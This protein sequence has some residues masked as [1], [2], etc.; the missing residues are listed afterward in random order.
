MRWIK[1]SA[2]LLI[3]SATT[4]VNAGLFDCCDKEPSC[5]A[6]APT[7]CDVQPTCCAPAAVHCPA[8]PNCCAP[9][10]TCCHDAACGPTYAGCGPSHHCCPPKKKC[11]LSRLWDCE[12]RKNRWIMNR[13]GW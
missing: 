8:A 2:A 5:C 1:L 7:C 10:P 6:P 11:F 13:M 9:G 4:Q 3:L 12:K